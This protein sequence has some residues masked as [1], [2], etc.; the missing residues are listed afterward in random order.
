MILCKTHALSLA[1]FRSFWII[2]SLK[3]SSLVVVLMMPLLSISS[4]AKGLDRLDREQ[5]ILS[6]CNAFKMA[7]NDADVLPCINFIEGFLNGVLNAKHTG[8]A[9]VLEDNQTAGTLVERAY[10]NRVGNKARSRSEPKA[11][12]DACLSMDKSRN[13]IVENLSNHSLSTI[14][15]LKQLNARLVHVLKTACSTDE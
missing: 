6:S 11:I 10:T 2:K 15:S 8:V 1:N 12:N 3:S 14:H 9:T 5:N 4:S 13:L 7:E